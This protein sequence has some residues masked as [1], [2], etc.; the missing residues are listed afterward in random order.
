MEISSSRQI[1]TL[2]W[3]EFG[4][5]WVWLG[6]LVGAIFVGISELEFKWFAV[7]L[8]GLLLGFAGLL[9]SDKKFFFLILLV[10]ALP[11]SI[12]INFYYHPS[13]VSHSTYGFQILLFDL[14]LGALY[15][16][17]LIR[18]IL[19]RQHLDICTTGLVAL[20]GLFFSA[21]ISV[22]LSDKPIYGFFDLFAIFFSVLLYSYVA[23]QI[24]TTDELLLIIVLLIANVA[25][26][27]V[28]ALAQHITDSNLG[29]D[30]FGA[31]KGLRDYASLLA[32]SRAGGTLGHPNSLA[33][34]FDLTLPLTFSI[35]FVP[36]R[37]TLRF[38][39]LLAVGI[40]LIGLAVTKSRGGM[41]A[42][43]FALVILLVI[44]LA[45]WYGKFQAFIYV[46][47]IS[48]LVGCLILGTSNPVR[49][50]F[51]KNDY[52]TAMGR[53]PHM[54]VALNLIRNNPLFGVGLNNYTLEAPR[55]DNTPQQIVASWEAPVHN[56][57]MFI[58]SE[59]GFVGIAWLFLFIISGMKASWPALHSKD[60]FIFAAGLGVFMGLIAFS[61][62]AQFDYAHWPQ[63]TILWFMLGLAVTLGR[64]ANTPP[65]INHRLS[66]T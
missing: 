17:W 24:Q 55:F 64:F 1:S 11:I 44:H 4:G 34:F 53:I 26:Q 62:H 2:T 27:G 66:H 28:I 15:L 59:I 25:I 63:F 46:G 43:G 20:L 5:W 41:L 65:K 8:S 37:F 38:L 21:S 56:L 52:G 23:S 54:E 30:F 57:Y 19:Q 47:L 32:L 40:G 13:E 42:V 48:T 49:T 39:L 36:K 31:T 22:L 45:R 18:A 3:P 51:F 10:L 6:I 50:R 60:P 61:I 12:H 14:P 16:I 35:M 58:A 33:L 9:F 7:L 29:L